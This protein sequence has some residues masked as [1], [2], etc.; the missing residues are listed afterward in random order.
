MKTTIAGVAA[1][2][3]LMSASAASAQTTFQSAEPRWFLGAN[4]LFQAGSGGLTDQFEFQ[5]FVETGTIESTYDAGSAIGLDGSLGV[6]VWRN[7]GVG[8]AVSTYAPKKGGEVTARIPHP[9]HFN[10]H[11]EVSGEASLSRKET[12]IHASL[13]YI[14]PAGERFQV[15]LGA[16][17]TFFQADQS[18]V[19]DVLYT[20]QYPFDTAT[21]NGVDIDNES[22]SG[23]GFNASL[24]IAWRF[25]RSFGVGGLLRY[26]QGTLPFTPGDRDVD[27]TVGGVQAGLGFRVIF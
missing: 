15:I 7:V 18:F 12:A 4:G 13:L 1:G 8:V 19:N 5:E 20:Q 17:P 2:L 23:I 25:S 11:R 10:Q 3:I 9:F 26:T 14:V 16:G 22:A 24:D 21:F 6:R 27:V